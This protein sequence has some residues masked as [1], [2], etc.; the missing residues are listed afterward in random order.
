MDLCYRLAKLMCSVV[1]GWLAGTALRFPGA[2]G[3]LPRKDYQLLGVAGAWW[4]RSDETIYPCATVEK[5]FGEGMSWTLNGSTGPA[6]VGTQARGAVQLHTYGSLTQ[7]CSKCGLETAG[8]VQE[9]NT[10]VSRPVCS[11]MQ[12]EVRLGSLC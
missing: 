7:Q 4:Q 6:K 8:L 12:I 11:G 3:L 9:T 5:N 10:S 1:L 2:A